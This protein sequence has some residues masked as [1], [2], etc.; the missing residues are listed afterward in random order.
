MYTTDRA[1]AIVACFFVGFVYI[2]IKTYLSPKLIQ[3]YAFCP[4]FFD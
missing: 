2:F 3:S 4:L 1:Q